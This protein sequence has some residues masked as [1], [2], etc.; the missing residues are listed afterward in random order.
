ML[1]HLRLW[2]R[3]ADWTPSSRVW[4]WVAQLQGVGLGAGLTGGFLGSC[5]LFCVS[6]MTVSSEGII[7]P[8]CCC[9]ASIVGEAGG[10]RMSAE[11]R[12][13]AAVC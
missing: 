5:V 6:E 4:A 7:P 2:S 9:S 1:Q 10:G 11:R 3:Q 12:G 13:T 8:L